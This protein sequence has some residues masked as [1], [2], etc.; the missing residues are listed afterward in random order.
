MRGGRIVKLPVA[1]GAAVTSSSDRRAQRKVYAMFKRSITLVTVRKCAYSVAEKSSVRFNRP[2]VF[3]QLASLVYHC[4][5]LPGCDANLRIK[6]ES[7]R[8]CC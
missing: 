5:Y 3:Y 6:I 7:L 2:P 1:S 8:L 4:E